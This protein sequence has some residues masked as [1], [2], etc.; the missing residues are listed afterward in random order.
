GDV[1]PEA[2]EPSGP[3][4][5]ETRGG[6]HRGDRLLEIPKTLAHVAHERKVQQLGAAKHRGVYSRRDGAHRRIR[7]LS[8]QRRLT[9]VS[10]NAELHAE[11]WRRIAIWMRGHEFA[12]VLR[13]L[14]REVAIGQRGQ[15]AERSWRSHGQSEQLGDLD[16]LGLRSRFPDLVAKD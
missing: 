13:M 15:A 6:R 8:R 11:V 1:W 14:I 16:R 5:I 10:A 12:D 7:R 3:N 4:L 9:H 2:G